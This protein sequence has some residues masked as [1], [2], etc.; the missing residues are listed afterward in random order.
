MWCGED[1][2]TCESSMHCKHIKRNI[3]LNEQ[4]MDGWMVAVNSKEEVICR[5]IVVGLRG[6][7]WEW[8]SGLIFCVKI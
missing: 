7:C 1:G 6:F 8:Q 3:V 4:A 5:N 2:T